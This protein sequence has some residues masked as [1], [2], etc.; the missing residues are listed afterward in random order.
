M[1]YDDA[2]Q[3]TPESTLFKALIEHP[4]VSSECAGNPIS[5]R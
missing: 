1:I 3:R 5:K 4:I 2:E